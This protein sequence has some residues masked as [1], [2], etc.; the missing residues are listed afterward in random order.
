MMSL[1]ISS[2]GEIT[3]LESRWMG[4]GKEIRFF[5]IIQT[6]MIGI[7]FVVVSLVDPLL[8]FLLIDWG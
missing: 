5:V 2:V 3:F 7:F 8:G 6:C 4:P 1:P